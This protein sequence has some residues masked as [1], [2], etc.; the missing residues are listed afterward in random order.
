[1]A[2]ITG[3]WTPRAMSDGQYGLLRGSRLLSEPIL[4][5]IVLDAW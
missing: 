1:M 2:L 3:C 5:M 4:D